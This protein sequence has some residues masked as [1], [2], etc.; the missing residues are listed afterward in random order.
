MDLPPRREFG[1]RTVNIIVKSPSR[2]N[3]SWPPTNVAVVLLVIAGNMIA[4]PLW[5]LIFAKYREECTSLLFEESDGSLF[6]KILD[7]LSRGVLETAPRLVA[8]FFL[9]YL[10]LCAGCVRISLLKE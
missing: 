1:G 10:G 4:Y 5:W 6:V 9:L 3:R 7:A 2:L 8:A